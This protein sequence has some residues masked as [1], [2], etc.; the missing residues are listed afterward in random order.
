MIEAF[1]NRVLLHTPGSRGARIFWILFLVLGPLCYIGGSILEQRGL[2]RNTDGVLL[3]RDGALATGQQ[4]VA[5][6]NIDTTNWGAYT[7]IDPSKDLLEYYRLHREP[8]TNAALSFVSPITLRVMMISG[9]QIAEVFLNRTGQV[10]GYDFTRVRAVTGGEP[11][12][13]SQAADIALAS[14][15]RIPNLSGLLTLGKPDV[16]TLDKA[17]RGCNSYTW[18]STAPSLPGTSFTV[19]SAVC[20]STVVKQMVTASVDDAYANAHWGRA[21]LPLKILLGIYS[22]YITIVVIYSIYRYARRALEREISHKRTMLIALA[23]AA[24]L[25]SNLLNGIDEYVFGLVLAGQGLI[26]YPMVAAFLAF[27]VGGLGLAVAYGAGEGDLREL[28]PGK[29]T[30]LDALMRGKLLS[31]N[32]GRAALFGISYGAWMLLLEG[33]ADWI[34]HPDTISFAAEIIKVPFLRDP[35]LAIFTKQAVIVTIVPASGLLLPLAFLGRKVRRP[36]LRTTL[37]V[38]FAAIACLESVS[39]YGSLQGAVVG[40]AVLTATLLGPFFGMDLLAV[41]FGLGAFEIATSLARLMVLSPS[42]L[43]LGASAG[44]IGVVAL[45]VAL[46]AA[47]RGREYREEEVRPQYAGN[48]LQRQAMQAELAAA[49][50]AQLHLLPKAPPEVVGLSISA[51]CIPARI[52]GGDFYDFY[53]LGEGRL[54]IFIA[55]GGNRGIGAAL[56]IALAKGFLM[57]TVRRNLSP[58][59]IIQRLESTVGKLLD[60]SGAATHVAYAVIDTVAGTLDYARTGEY[61]RVVAGALTSEQKFEVPGAAAILYEGN[62]KLGDGDTVLLFTDGIARRVRTTGPRAADGILK[63]LARKRRDHELEDDLTAVV[64]RIL[65]VG[66]A[67][68]VVA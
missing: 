25:M 45:A 46:W 10:I 54:G 31:R 59:E 9:A 4:F 41:I 12:Q 55:E 60:T 2:G 15:Q 18:H 64:I 63:A 38:L 48:I 65:N 30:S 57:H 16:A 8:A 17:G 24:A 42:W 27:L 23:I 62:A 21:A 29:L 66:R 37:M 51:A 19:A 13:H 33:A 44:A 20:G 67:M 3:D 5:Q 34:L 11:L 68:E 35:L 28:Y 22:L 40:T 1:L 52:V 49:R 47:L 56:N 58:R 36:L 50:E 53:A 39:R 32:V 26:W 7:S 6:S 43:Q 61:P 14:V